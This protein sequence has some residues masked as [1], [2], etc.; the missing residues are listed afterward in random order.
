MT[1]L[2]KLISYIENDLPPYDICITLHI[3][4]FYVIY[5]T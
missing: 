4:L 1:C 2:G 5:V 3:Y